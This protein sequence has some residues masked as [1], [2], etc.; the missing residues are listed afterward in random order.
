MRRELKEVVLRKLEAAARW[1]VYCGEEEAGP[2]GG[3]VI[4]KESPTMLLTLV[5][6]SGCLG[7]GFQ[8]NFQRRP[9][10]GKPRGK[11]KPP[12]CCLP[13][14]GEKS[15]PKIRKPPKRLGQHRGSAGSAPKA[16]MSGMPAARQVV[17]DISAWRA[18][19]RGLPNEAR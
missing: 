7:K 13:L 12:A 6:P 1:L 11:K 4:R 2:E 16:T 3:I 19:A 8:L 9:R 17:I 14:Q 5:C 15:A 18:G 10:E